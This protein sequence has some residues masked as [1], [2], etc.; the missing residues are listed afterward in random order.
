MKIK[1]VV[2]GLMLLVI[3]GSLAGAQDL[4]GMEPPSGD[5]ENYDITYT[6]PTGDGDKWFVSHVAHIPVGA[7]GGYPGNHNIYVNTYDWTSWPNDPNIPE[8]N[9]HVPVRNVKIAYWCSGE[10]TPS[11]SNEHWIVQETWPDDPDGDGTDFPLFSQNTCKVAVW[12]EGEPMSSGIVSNLHTRHADEG[13]DVRWGH[14]SFRVNFTRLE[15][16]EPTP[17]STPRPSPTPASTWTPGPTFTATPTETPMA[18]A[19]PVDVEQIIREAA[20]NHAYP[21]GGVRFNPDAAFQAVARERGYGAP[22][23][24]EFDLGE[25]RA[26]GFSAT[27]LHCVVGDWQNIKVMLW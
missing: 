25:H 13:D 22:V 19:T 12:V 7:N 26:Q 15:P 8:G 9:L 3:V 2:L 4:F 11:P 20:W 18:T 1:Y 14:H 5:W 10:D 17:T 27:I 21:A 6:V 23:T 24:N 16:G